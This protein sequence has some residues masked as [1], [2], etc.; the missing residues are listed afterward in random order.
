V[1]AWDDESQERHSPQGVSVRSPK[2]QLLLC[3]DLPRSTFLGLLRDAALLVG[4]SSAGIIEAASFGTPVVDIGRR[5]EGRERSRNVIH[6]AN[7]GAQIRSAVA[8]VWKNGQ[9]RRSVAANVYGAGGA[10]IRV[11]TTLARLDLERHRRKLIT[12]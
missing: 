4:N 10:A 12:F 9:P 6:V 3:R 2:S 1:R 11:A 5:Q 7:S 8:R